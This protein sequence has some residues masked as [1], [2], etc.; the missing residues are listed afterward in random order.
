MA[1]VAAGALGFLTLIQVFD[2]RSF[3]SSI[4]E[5]TM[6]RKTKCKALTELPWDD[7]RKF[8]KAFQEYLGQLSAT[9]D[10]DGN[11][12]DDAPSSGELPDPTIVATLKRLYKEYP[13]VSDHEIFNRICPDDKLREQFFDALIRSDPS[14]RG[15]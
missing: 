12:R 6:K 5:G 15:S 3:A 7:E 13:N 11:L 14:L 9:F 2:G 8:E 1:R 4:T 10:G